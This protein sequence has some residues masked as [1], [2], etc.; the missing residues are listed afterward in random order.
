[1]SLSI[2]SEDSKTLKT[3]AARLN[4]MFESFNQKLDLLDKLNVNL[5]K[6]TKDDVLINS[7]KE[8]HSTAKLALKT[9]NDN[10]VVISKI[11]DSVEKMEFKFN[12]L[13]RENGQ[14]K[15]QVK[16]N[17]NY[18][19][20]N[21]LV[22]RGISEE[23]GDDCEQ[24]V[25]TFMKEQLK[26]DNEFISNVKF[27]R[28]HRLGGKDAGQTWS[29]P[30]IVRFFFFGDRRRVWAQRHQLANTTYSLSENFC[31]QTEFNRKK[32]YPIYRAA[33][34]LPAYSRKTTMVADRLILDSKSYDIDTIDQLP[35]AIHPRNYA[36]K[37]DAN[38]IVF[39]GVLSEYDCFSNWSASPIKY[40]GNDYV[41]VEQAYMHVK[42]KDNGCPL[43]AKHVMYTNDSREIK[44]IGAAVKGNHEWHKKKKD[45]MLQIVRAKFTQNEKL[46]KIL[47]DSGNRKLG[48]TGKDDF[49]S[50]GLPLTARNVLNS[51]NWKAQSQL[52]NILET[53]RSELK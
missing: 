21:N 31:G 41:S 43:A 47:L 46:K 28:C 18:V 52:G 11:Q 4:V 12:A 48:E 44:E 39:G 7:V 8:A 14:L 27:V 13:V 35:E 38:T 9:A 22:V 50:I 25:R 1:M 2:S 3:M 33:K 45:V 40:E 42:A 32:L 29:R 53:V 30:I 34:V 6:L 5:D 23:G 51:N 10:S 16:N 24:L 37:T 36:R 17:D 49:F 20:R 19:R 26:F 15:E